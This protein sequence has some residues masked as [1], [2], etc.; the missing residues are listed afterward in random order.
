MAE[1]EVTLNQKDRTGTSL[2]IK[3]V[4]GRQLHVYRKENKLEKTYSVDILS[5]QDKSK[6]VFS[7]AWKWLIASISFFLVMLI[8]LKFLPAYLGDDKNLYLGIIL[9]AGI[10]GS[11]LCFSRFC[12]KTSKKHIFYTRNAHVPIIVLS[13]GKPSKNTF[14]SF[15]NAIEKRIKKFRDHMDIAEDKQLTGEMKM[16]RRLSDNGVITKKVYENA[17]KKLFSGFSNGATN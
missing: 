1:N 12:M 9:L 14:R 5:L 3:L 17:K 4:E 15:V 10:I 13:A 8:L 6:N 11:L 16:L 7:I 2:Q